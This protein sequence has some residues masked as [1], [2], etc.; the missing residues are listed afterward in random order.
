MVRW[1]SPL[2]L[3]SFTDCILKFA[4]LLVSIASWRLDSR[5]VE[6]VCFMESYASSS[7]LDGIFLGTATDGIA[8]VLTHSGHGSGFECGP[9]ARVYACEADETLA[10]RGRPRREVWRGLSLLIDRKGILAAECGV[11]TNMGPCLG[12]AL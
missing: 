8:A 6:R 11:F 4:L 2:T 12:Y 9:R 10:R 1:V 7:S 5:N 3:R